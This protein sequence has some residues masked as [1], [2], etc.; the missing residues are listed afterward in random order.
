MWIYL[1]KKRGTSSDD[2]P[3]KKFVY[4]ISELHH[5]KLNLT[6]L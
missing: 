3:A 2:D 5:E 4:H 1:I 6:Q